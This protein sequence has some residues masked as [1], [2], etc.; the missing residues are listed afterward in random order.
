MIEN[1][2][3]GTLFFCEEKWFSN[4][5]LCSTTFQPILV[6]V[7]FSLTLNLFSHFL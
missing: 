6:L 4:T 7:I 2:K 1:P 5:P 3:S